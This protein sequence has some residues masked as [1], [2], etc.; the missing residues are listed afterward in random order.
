MHNSAHD[1]TD[2]YT[3]CGFSK[4][5]SLSEYSHFSGQSIFVFT[6]PEP[7]IMLNFSGKDLSLVD[8]A[9][10]GP[11]FSGP[12]SDSQLLG[13]KNANGSISRRPTP[14]AY[15]RCS[16]SVGILRV[17]DVKSHLT[18]VSFHYLLAP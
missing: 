3:P 7:K 4:I 11:E 6:A 12:E 1:K 10:A 15:L 13:H 8:K 9:W 14:G 2:R 16:Q 18:R 5:T 17:P